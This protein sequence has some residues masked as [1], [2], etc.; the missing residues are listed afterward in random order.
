MKIVLLFK[1][2][3]DFLNEYIIYI[4]IY[5]MAHPKKQNLDYTFILKLSKDDREKL[6][7]LQEGGWNMSQ[8][9]RNM[10]RETYERVEESKKIISDEKL[11]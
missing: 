3:K 8:F 2:I 1:K 10:L 11:M 5:S 9:F 6:N 7:E 4:I